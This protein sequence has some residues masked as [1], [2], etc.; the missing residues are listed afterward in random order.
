MGFIVFARVPESQKL[1][2]VANFIQEQDAVEYCEFK[3][4]KAAVAKDKA[5]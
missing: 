3:N 1:K 4:I 5:K 2:E